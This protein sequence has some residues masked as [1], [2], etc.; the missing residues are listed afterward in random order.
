[1][2]VPKI[3]A[4]QSWIAEEAEQTRKSDAWL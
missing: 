3:R 2:R 1:V 4:F